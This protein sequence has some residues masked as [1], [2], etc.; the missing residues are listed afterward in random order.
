MYHA[1]GI[2]LKMSTDN[3]QIGGWASYFHPPSEMKHGPGQFTKIDGFSPWAANIMTLY[4]FRQIHAALHL[5]SGS[6]LVGDKWH[7]LRATTES[8][9]Q[10]ASRTFILGCE[11]LFDKGG[12]ASKSQYNPVQQ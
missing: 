8:L 1:F 4:C 10:H 3:H 12:I 9:N 6:R 11:C 5:E 2:I 7:Q